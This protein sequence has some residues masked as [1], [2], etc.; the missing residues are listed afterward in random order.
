MKGVEVTVF[1]VKETLS[2]EVLQKMGAP[3]K[4]ENIPEATADTV[5]EYDGILFGVSTFGDLIP[6]GIYII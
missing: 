1:R 3:K 2:E 4:A 5:A 6:T